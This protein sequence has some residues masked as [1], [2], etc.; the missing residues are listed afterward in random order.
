MNTND[1][2]P[3]GKVYIP[4]GFFDARKCGDDTIDQI[5]GDGLVKGTVTMLYGKPGSGKTTFLLQY[6]DM[7][8]QKDYKTAYG[9]WEEDKLQIAKNASR[10]GVLEVNVGNPDNFECFIEMM[11]YFDIIVIDSF[12]FLKLKQKMTNNKKEEYVFTTLQKNA[13]ET[14][15]NVFVIVHTTKGGTYKGSTFMEHGVDA[16]LRVSNIEEKPEYKCFSMDKNRFGQSNFGI[17]IKM[18]KEGFDFSSA[19]V[20]ELI[21]HREV[22]RISKQEQS[23]LDIMTLDTINFHSVENLLGVQEA[24]ARQLLNELVIDGKLIK[25]GYG[26]NSSWNK[27]IIDNTESYHDYSS[28]TTK[29]E[30]ENLCA[31]I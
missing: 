24:R 10:I 9:S 13:R 11:T 17:D 18:T 25:R 20:A 6:L 30:N 2:E 4:E 23:K 14:G 1:F 8:Q 19:S 21:E 16:V 27:T 3:T 15:C 5:F 26:R 28:E 31:I 22:Q 7:L 29:E 12:Q